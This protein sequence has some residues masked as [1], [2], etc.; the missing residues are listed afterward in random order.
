MRCK[1]QQISIRKPPCKCS[2]KQT[3][4]TPSPATC[5]NGWR[6]ASTNCKPRPSSLWT[7]I[8]TGSNKGAKAG[9]KRIGEGLGL[10][11]VLGTPGRSASSG[12]RWARWAGQRS[13]S[14]SPASRR[15][16][17]SGRLRIRSHRQ[18]SDGGDGG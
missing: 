8:G 9:G 17:W 7:T 16:G 13:P 5:V 18:N 1:S 4:K 15:Q 12:T 6:N 2:L 10:G 14:P 11:F 3:R